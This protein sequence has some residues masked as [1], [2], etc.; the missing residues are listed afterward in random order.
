M[1]TG[2]TTTV[3][4]KKGAD[5]LENN[6]S[7]LVLKRYE[8]YGNSQLKIVIDN[9]LQGHDNKRIA[10]CMYLKQDVT[11]HCVKCTVFF[12]SFQRRQPVKT[13]FFFRRMR[14]VEEHIASIGIFIFNILETLDSKTISIDMDLNK[15]RCTF[16]TDSIDYGYAFLVKKGYTESR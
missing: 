14:F 3:V 5:D 6:N 2:T 10:N 15:V 9:L 12:P 13:F 7:L 11:T 8:I 4:P 16:S 1:Q